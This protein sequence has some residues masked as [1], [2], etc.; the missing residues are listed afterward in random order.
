MFGWVMIVLVAASW[1]E[2]GPESDQDTGDS[3]APK[4]TT[5]DA[6]DLGDH[7]DQ[8]IAEVDRLISLVRECRDRPPLVGPAGPPVPWADPPAP[9]PQPGPPAPDPTPAP[10]VAPR[11][12]A[13]AESPPAPPPFGPQGPLP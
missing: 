5:Q 7:L 1:A 10:V 12:P 11:P 6:R 8:Q 2:S 13:P 3:G 9:A 4:V